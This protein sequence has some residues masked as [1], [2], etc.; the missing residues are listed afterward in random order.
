MRRSVA[1][2]CLLTSCPL[3]SACSF[4]SPRSAHSAFRAC[5]SVAL[6]R[7]V[8]VVSSSQFFFFSYQIASEGGLDPDGGRLLDEAA[9][10]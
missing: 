5:V 3:T 7:S 6:V 10:D 2:A 4:T 9:A 1:L 8:T